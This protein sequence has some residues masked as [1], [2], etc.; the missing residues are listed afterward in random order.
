MKC[1]FCGTLN[2]VGSNFCSSCG[3]SLSTNNNIIDNDQTKNINEDNITQETFEEQKV[4]SQEN[5]INFYESPNVMTNENNMGDNVVESMSLDDTTSSKKNKSNK[6]TPIIVGIVSL[7]LVAILAILAVFM[8]KPSPKRIFTGF[9]NKLYDYAKESLEDKYDTVYVNISLKPEIQ[10]TESKELESMV[11]KVDIN[12]SGGI[13]YKNKQFIY[14]LKANYD[15]ESLLDVDMQ[16]D[17]NFYMI[18][19]NLYDK[20]IM[21]EENDFN[22]VFEKAD[23]EDLNVVVRSYVTAFNNSLR[24]EYLTNEDKEITL[25]GIKTKVKVTTLDLNTS[26]SKEISDDI[27]DYLLKDK[28]F[29][30][31]YAKISDKTE[32]EVKEDLNSVTGEEISS[33]V[34]ISLYTKGL[35]HGFVKLVISS[36]GNNVEISS[37]SN[38]NNCVIKISNS[39]MT[40]LLDMTL[41]AKY[42]EKIDLKDVSNAVK[43]EEISSNALQILQNFTE[44]DGYKVLNEDVKEVTGSSIDELMSLLM[45]SNSSSDDYNYND[46]DSYSY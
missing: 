2:E 33:D 6:K 11:K 40:I 20:P 42:N 17:K 23:N 15:N 1:S 32:S 43:S 41:E 31:S 25:N 5:N 21:T 26:N 35:M 36:D 44:Q 38:D 22:D 9:T 19:N 4:D 29:I 27:I 3:S 10:G 14:N 37:G 13:D 30:K 46:Y 24:D 45:V 7:V 8:F 39:E 16:Y 18:L 28:E 34:K 12:L